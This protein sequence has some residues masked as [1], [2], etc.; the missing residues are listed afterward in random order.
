M[1]GLINL[2]VVDLVMLVMVLTLTLLW[3][4]LTRA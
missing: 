3:L 2:L 4:V 1:W